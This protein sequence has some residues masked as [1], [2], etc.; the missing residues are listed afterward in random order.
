M[1]RHRKFQRRPRS[2]KTFIINLR[3][4]HRAWNIDGSC[5]H[6][7][8]PGHRSWIKYWE[9]KTRCVRG[10]CSFHMCHRDANHGGHIWIKSLGPTIVPICSTC[11]DPDN[12][13]RMQ[14][15]NA[16]LKSKTKAVKIKM[17]TDMKQASRRFACSE[18]DSSTEEDSDSDSMD[19]RC[20]DCDRNID[21]RPMH[22]TKCYFCWRRD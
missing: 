19:R 7:P 5:S 8:P 17:T 12:T 10:M 18:S 6:R 16:Y 14:N 9:F 11:N 2:K 21:D 15:S 4:R 1:P 13:H 3:R 20:Q 22:H